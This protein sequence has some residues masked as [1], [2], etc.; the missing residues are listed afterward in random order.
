MTSLPPNYN[1]FGSLDFYIGK[2]HH[3]IIKTYSNS[4]DDS[5]DQSSTKI[6]HNMREGWL[7]AL[8]LGVRLGIREQSV[9]RAKIGSAGY[10]KDPIAI[11]FMIAVGINELC[12]KDNP[13]KV[14]NM[15]ED[16]KIN[17]ILK[18]CEE[19]VNG[20]A[21]TLKTLIEKGKYK[22]DYMEKFSLNLLRFIEDPA[23]VQE[24]DGLSAVIQ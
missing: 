8:A 23:S 18:I 10:I 19:Y 21:R 2:D 14:S 16:E 20:G 6:F 13:I 17:E 3:E 5:D 4:S 12:L 7:I 1:P 15:L 24:E 11:T 22:P 9:E